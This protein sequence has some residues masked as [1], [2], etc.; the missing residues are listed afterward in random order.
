MLMSACMRNGRALFHLNW[1]LLILYE[2]SLH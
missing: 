1:F 2:V